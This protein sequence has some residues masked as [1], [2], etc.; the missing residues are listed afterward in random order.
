M[1]PVASALIVDRAVQEVM[2]GG[3]DLKNNVWYIPA[4][5]AGIPQAEEH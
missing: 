5:Q 4:V 2:G 3:I 1:G